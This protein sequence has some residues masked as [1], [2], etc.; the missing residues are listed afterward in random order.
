MVQEI[1]LSKINV[2]TPPAENDLYENNIIFT[3][4]GAKVA[5]LKLVPTP[6]VLVND[7]SLE[8]LP[9]MTFFKGGLTVE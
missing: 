1:F 5:E 4:P 8:A 3:P 9:R 7:W 2:Q 6:R